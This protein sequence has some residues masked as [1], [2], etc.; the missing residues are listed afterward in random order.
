MSEWKEVILGDVI[1][2]NTQ[3]IGREYPYSEIKYLDTG[4]ITCNRIDSLQTYK[5]NE[6]P[7]R[8]KRLV[9]NGDIIYSS[10]RPNQLHYGFIENPIENLVV[11]TGFVVITCKKEALEPQFLYYFLSQ[12]STTEYLHSIAEASTS[13]YPSL[14]PS[15]IEALELLLPS[16][17][18]Q[19]TIASILRSIDDKINLLK[20]QSF[21]LEKL[22]EILFKKWFLEEAKEEWNELPLSKIAVFLNGLACQKFPPKSEIDKL[23]VLKIKELSSGITE[24]SDWASTDIKPEYI[25]RNGDVIFAWSAS[26][27]VKIWEGQDCILNQHL[28]KVTS[29]DYPKW[30][31]YLW[32]KHHLA[33]FIS[34]A[35]SH[36]TTMGHI[37]RGDLDEAKVLIPSPD[38]LAVMTEQAEP[39]IQKIIENNIQI[40]TLIKL[41]YSL[42]PKL[43]SGEVTV[44]I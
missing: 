35:A 20:R 24:N 4:S 1:D 27:M 41:R 37:K 42:L 22:A 7:S 13:T 11:S 39:L 10:V 19:K 38:E 31:Y 16:I 9:K 25:V 23:P 8:A 33:E 12:E 5:L 2:T 44:E 15:D 18:V 26:L 28:F 21:V 17:Q 6:A 3:S 34:I 36:A 32:C 40:N 29:A 30:F 43:M 14:K